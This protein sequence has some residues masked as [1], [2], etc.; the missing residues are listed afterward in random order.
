MCLYVGHRTQDT[1]H[2]TQVTGHRTQDTGH[3]TQGTGH[4]TQ[5]T[6]H[7]TQELKEMRGYWKLKEEALDRTAWRSRCGRGCEH[8][9]RQTAE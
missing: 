2:R 5:D 6:G 1:G 7:R 3:R 9:V 8:V 4:R